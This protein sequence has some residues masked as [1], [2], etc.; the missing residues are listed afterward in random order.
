MVYCFV[1]VDRFMVF[2][3]Q[4]YGLRW[5]DLLWIRSDHAFFQVKKDL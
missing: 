1:V 2:G 4:I 3:G 5:T